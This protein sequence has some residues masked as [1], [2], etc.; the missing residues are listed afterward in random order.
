M[1]RDFKCQYYNLYAKQQREGQSAVANLYWY[2]TA[3]ACAF[4]D[5]RVWHASSQ[6]RGN[7]KIF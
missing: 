1:K 4:A 7:N 3:E 6:R 5:K 2:L